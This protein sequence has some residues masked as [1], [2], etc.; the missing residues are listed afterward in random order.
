MS[1]VRL[2][3]ATSLAIGLLASPAQAGRGGALGSDVRSLA[4][5]RNLALATAGLGVSAIVYRWDRPTGRVLREAHFLRTTSKATDVYGE[6][7]FC[8]PSAVGIYLLARVGHRPAIR[9]ASCDVLRALVLTQAV[10]APMK[11]LARRRRPDG[12]NRRSF[13][14]GHAANASAIA[15]VSGN[16]WGPRAS[17]P[18]SLVAGL[19]GAGRVS[20][21]HHHFSDVLAG[22][23]LGSLVGCSV[24]RTGDTRVSVVPMCSPAGWALC[25][26]VRPPK[27][28]PGRSW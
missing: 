24:T 5:V 26:S 11:Q 22:S 12:S 28:G 20:G 27:R 10:V 9:S 2:V 14:S 13:P 25:L 17:L 3:V 23:V 7:L 1:T 19:V 21:S 8:V 16:R 18:L 15:A 4:T 6:T